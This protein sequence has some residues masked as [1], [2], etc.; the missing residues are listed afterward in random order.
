MLHHRRWRRRWH[1]LIRD[2]PLHRHPIERRTQLIDGMS[3][4][5]AKLMHEWWTEVLAHWHS[6]WMVWSRYRM[7]IVAAVIVVIIVI[8]KM[9]PAPIPLKVSAM[10]RS[11]RL[12]RL[13]TLFPLHAQFTISIL[14]FAT[15]VRVFRLEI[16]CF[17][18]GRCIV[19]ACR[20]CGRLLRR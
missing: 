18:C 15:L 20:R 2:R 11:T 14:M 7:S 9:R 10:L 3:V 16:V 4:R 6:V 1:S 8:G 19:V 13:I 5:L 17:R 12:L